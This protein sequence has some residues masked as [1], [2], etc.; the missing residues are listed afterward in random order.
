M[1]QN[2]LR[3]LFNGFG[4]NGYNGNGI[5]ATLA[6]PQIA[7][8]ICISMEMCTFLPLPHKYWRIEYHTRATSLRLTNGQQTIDIFIFITYLVF[9]KLI[10]L[11]W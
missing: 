9:I 3:R 10:K 11:A 8:Q 4:F 1:T 6:H 2:R 5:V 7:K